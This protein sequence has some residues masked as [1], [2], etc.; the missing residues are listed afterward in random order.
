MFAFTLLLVQ[1]CIYVG[2]KVIEVA[3]WNEA[4]KAVREYT[5]MQELK[6]PTLV[7][8][9]DCHNYIYHAYRSPWQVTALD[10]HNYIG[11]EHIGAL[12]GDCAR[13]PCLY[14]P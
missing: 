7:S 9:L 11:P 13:L 3:S 12:A 1:P 6:H 14:R 5:K 4:Q 8:A 2:L 10:C